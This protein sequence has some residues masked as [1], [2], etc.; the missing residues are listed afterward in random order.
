VAGAG[1]VDDAVA[2][3]V[4]RVVVGVVVVEHVMDLEEQLEMGVA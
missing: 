2:K 4:V 1:A 3:D